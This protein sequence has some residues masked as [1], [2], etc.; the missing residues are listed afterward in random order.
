MN[1]FRTFFAEDAYVEKI[2]KLSETWPGGY[3]MFLRACTQDGET[4]S[5]YMSS[6]MILTDIANILPYTQYLGEEPIYHPG[7]LPFLV[8]LVNQHIQSAVEQ[9]LNIDNPTDE[10]IT[11][12]LEQL[13]LEFLTEDSATELLSHVDISDQPYE[14]VM[15]RLGITFLN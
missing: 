5:H 10:D 12:A 11:Q 8:G 1:T 14:Q 6:G 9:H 3:G 2:R 13:G 7:N 15:T 4:I